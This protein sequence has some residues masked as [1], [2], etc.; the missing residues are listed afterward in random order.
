MA[1]ANAEISKIP[2]NFVILNMEKWFL[3]QAFGFIDKEIIST[4]IFDTRDQKWKKSM[5]SIDIIPVSRSKT[6]NIDLY[7]LLL[8]Q[9]TL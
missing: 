4:N 2:N 6:T 5:H 7:V 1:A 3:Y 8:E 9:N